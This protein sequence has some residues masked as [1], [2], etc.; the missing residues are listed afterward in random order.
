MDPSKEDEAWKIAEE[1]VMEVDKVDSPR[2]K[3]VVLEA[4]GFGLSID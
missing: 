1:E 4:S 2:E 3:H